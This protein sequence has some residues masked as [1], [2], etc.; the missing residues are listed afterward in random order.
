MKLLINV[1]EPNFER[2]RGVRLIC[3]KPNHDVT[4]IG[5]DTTSKTYLAFLP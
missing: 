3:F 4:I 2:V 5:Y 1:Q